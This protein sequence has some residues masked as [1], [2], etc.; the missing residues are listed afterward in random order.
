MKELS[1][2]IDESGDKSTHA[3]YF[4]LTVV[5]HDQANKIADKINAYEQAL[6][7]ATFPISLFIP[8]LC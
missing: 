6:A 1:V 8:N 2:F 5:I 7:I 3:R 4:L